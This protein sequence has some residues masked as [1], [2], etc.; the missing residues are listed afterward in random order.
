[1]SLTNSAQNTEISPNFLARKLCENAQ[2]PQSFWIFARN[3]AETVRLHKI[4]TPG[5]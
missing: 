3:S 1:M 4:S 5:N 2:L